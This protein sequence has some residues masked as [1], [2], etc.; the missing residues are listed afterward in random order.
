MLSRIRSKGSGWVFTPADFLDL[1]GRTAIDLALLRHKRNGTIRQL[2]RGI[3]DR[4]SRH[5]RIGLLSPSVG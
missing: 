5:A 1:G 4:P 2:A 3:Y